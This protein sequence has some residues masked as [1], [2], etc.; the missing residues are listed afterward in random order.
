MFDDIDYAKSRLEDTAVYMED[1]LVLI[2]ELEDE[3]VYFTD[4]ETEQSSNICMYEADIDLKPFPLGYIDCTETGKAHF[5]CRTPMRRWR[6]GLDIRGTFHVEDM[7]I[8][9]LKVNFWNLLKD[10][11]RHHKQG[12]D[13]LEAAYMYVVSTDKPR[14]LSHSFAL[15]PSNRNGFLDL[16]YTGSTIGKYDLETN[17]VEL[18]PEF[19]YIREL[20]TFEVRV[21]P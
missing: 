11:H 21:L 16:K 15:A 13:S 14:A 6:Q 19:R 10:I 20:L 18:Y 2:N 3:R 9:L 17:K 8:R 1:R 12:C 4:V 5:V 7:A